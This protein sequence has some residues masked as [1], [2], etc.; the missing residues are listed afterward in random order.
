MARKK[1]YL[2]GNYIES[3]GT[4]E[5][6]MLVNNFVMMDCGV[7][8]DPKWMPK[9]RAFIISMPYHVLRSMLA[10]KGLAFAIKN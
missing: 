1:M 6:E 7:R 8:G 9:H 4:L 2:A 5:S 10:H 3:F